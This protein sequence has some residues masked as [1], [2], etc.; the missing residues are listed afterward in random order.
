MPDINANLRRAYGVAGQQALQ[1]Q[2]P[3]PPVGGYPP[4][5]DMPG[6]A[7]EAQ[8]KMLTE[9]QLTAQYDWYARQAGFDGVEN[10][11]ASHV[12]T[13]Y[14]RI[15]TTT[16]QDPGSPVSYNT[17]IP[18]GVQPLRFYFQDYCFVRRVTAS[19]EGMRILQ[20][21][22]DQPGYDL[23]VRGLDRIYVSLR[24][25]G[26]GDLFMTD[27]IPLSHFAG[28]GDDTYFWQ[29]IPV[30]TRQE[31]WRLDI[32]IIPPG[33]PS[34]IPPFIRSLGSLQVCFHTQRFAP[35]GI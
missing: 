12:V 26:P 31:R 2:G 10:I 19:F 27:P 7:Y 18:N 17:N 6:N 23:G 16:A 33:N 35:L 22:Q 13:D 28:T 3:N 30:V 9:H 4:P 5:L 34:Q 14:S 11:L 32:S 20:A 21:G 24:R 8:F 15:S 1:G 25:E 29:L